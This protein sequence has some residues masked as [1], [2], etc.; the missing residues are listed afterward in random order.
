[1]RKFGHFFLEIIGESR[2]L[3]RSSLAEFLCPSFGINCDLLIE[4]FRFE[5]R[6]QCASILVYDSPFCATDYF[7]IIHRGILVDGLRVFDAGGGENTGSLHCATDG[8][9]VRRFGRDDVFLI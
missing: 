4:M 2:V 3:D 8:E 5:E 6:L 9:A 7:D 1:M